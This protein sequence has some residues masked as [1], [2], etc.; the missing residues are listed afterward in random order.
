MEGCNPVSTPNVKLTND[1]KPKN[2][3]EQKYMKKVPYREVV[4]KLQYT[5]QGTR[6]DI[7][8]AVNTVSRYLE[9]P[10]KEHWSAVKRILRYLKGT[11]DLKL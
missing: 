7:T 1:M 4:G 10:G 6:P 2:Q 9:N 8:F 11:L 5:S 3:E